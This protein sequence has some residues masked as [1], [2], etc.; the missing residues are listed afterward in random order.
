MHRTYTTPAV[1]QGRF[2]L[3]GFE[4]AGTNT[5]YLGKFM[6]LVEHHVNTN[7]VGGT[8]KAVVCDAFGGCYDSPSATYIPF[9]NGGM[10][11]A[12]YIIYTNSLTH[13]ERVSV[14]QYLSRKWFGKNIYYTVTD[15]KK[16]ELSPM[17]ASSVQLQVPPGK[18][19]AYESLE[20]GRLTKIGSGRMYLKTLLGSDIEVKEGELLLSAWDRN[21][22]VPPDSW[23]HVAADASDTIV[24]ENDG[25]A[26]SRWK[27]L[28]LPG[29]SL[30]NHL[31]VKAKIVSA[32]NG[33][34][35]RPLVDLGEKDK[36]A[37]LK[38]EGVN[39]TG[40]TKTGFA[41]YDSAAGGGAFF[42]S[43]VHGFPSRGFP[44]DRTG[45]EYPPV[46]CDGSEHGT[47]S[48][49]GIPAMRTA[50]A[51]GSA[52][53]R[54]NGSVIDP[55]EV[56]FLF[57][58]ER[59]SFRYPAGRQILHFGAYGQS[60]QFNGGLKLGEMILF[61]RELTDGEMASTEAY[62]AK[63]WFDVDTPGYGSAAN[64]VEV[65]AG[66]KLTVLGEGFSVT[67]LSGGGV[68]DGDVRLA[69]GGTIAIAVGEDGSAAALSINGTL[70]LGGGR[71]EI[72]GPEKNLLPGEWTVITASKIEN[73]EG[74]WVLPSS[75]RR[76]YSLAVSETSV[77]L[78]VRKRG[79]SVIFR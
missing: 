58:P 76:N 15:E 20:G 17:S 44:H 5:A 45:G 33:M 59:F 68:I 35:G 26:L 60:S 64:K 67:S 70:S 74:E 55:F 78:F 4:V 48:W 57:A 52:V 40:L 65:D 46:V 34:N 23:L 10:R 54:R 62:L 2:Y 49:T 36:G 56:P 7:L 41:V 31:S 18:D 53:F 72:I 79:F 1:T 66:A 69:D 16:K 29:E 30:V 3:N 38:Y 50:A 22:L 63:K 12:E 47:A 42:G 24:T 32:E 21:L 11:I 13:A 73:A 8:A 37:A 25:V 61:E 77:R 19:V 6:Q 43:V 51:N 28:N 9:S 27:A 39:S 14:A 75:G 71:I